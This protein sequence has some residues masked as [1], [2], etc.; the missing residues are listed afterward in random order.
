MTSKFKIY[1]ILFFLFLIEI[2]PQQKVLLNINADGVQ[3]VV[4]LDN[5]IPIENYLNTFSECTSLN[6]IKDVNDTLRYFENYN[7]EFE[8]NTDFGFFSHDA[9]LQWYSVP[10]ELVIQELWWKNIGDQDST[11]GVRVRSWRVNEKIFDIPSNAV[12][13]KGR[14]G[15]YESACDTCGLQVTPYKSDSD[16]V[17]KVMGSA[18]TTHLYFDPL[19]EEYKQGDTTVTLSSDGWQGVKI[20]GS[21]FIP[22]MQPFGF[23]IENLAELSGGNERI[24]IMSKL[25][26]DYDST[27]HFNPGHSMK[28]YSTRQNSDSTIGWQIRRY[29]WGLFVLA[30]IVTDGPALEFDFLNDQN[31][32]IINSEN[33]VQVKINNVGGMAQ[34]TTVDAAYLKYK[35]GY[36]PIFETKPMSSLQ[37]TYYTTI[38]PF[39]R[40]E[41]LFMYIVAKDIYGNRF[42]SV[43]KSFQL[44]TSVDDISNITNSFNLDQNYPNPFNPKTNIIYEIPNEGKVTLKIF[45]ILGNEIETLVDKI[46]SGGRYNYEWYAGAISSGIY[47]AQ[48][49]YK[50]SIK[51]IKL[52]LIK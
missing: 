11:T 20:D 6:R 13:D 10:V 23:T 9:A 32:F 36:V 33:D 27:Q 41:P 45:D 2:Y 25:L 24:G 30:I 4:P 38:P 7:E 31:S 17:L 12:D 18:D 1:I 42:Q 35:L 16:S 40:E 48:L 49:R 26:T 28:F 29:E 52:L 47:L 19:L 34:P 3:E 51:I 21:W 46:Q 8:L 50:N 14:L 5:N 22:E 44:V 39:D 37:D 43:I 15:Y